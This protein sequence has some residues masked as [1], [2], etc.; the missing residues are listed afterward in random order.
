[1]LEGGRSERSREGPK[2]T[3]HSDGE[4]VRGSPMITLVLV[5][6]KPHC[7]CGVVRF[8]PRSR[9]HGSLEA[10]PTLVPERVNSLVG[11]RVVLLER[12]R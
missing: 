6:L 2:V 10:T 11:N 5:T 3:I 9:C 12:C 1:M 4:G 7:R 8:E